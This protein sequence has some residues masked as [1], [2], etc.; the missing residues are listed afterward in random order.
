MSEKEEAGLENAIA[1][2]EAAKEL[3]A[4][5]EVAE[6]ETRIQLDRTT[7]TPKHRHTIPPRNPGVVGPPG[8]KVLD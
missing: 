4:A 6:L 1:A 8:I 5:A 3:A 2:F 7:K